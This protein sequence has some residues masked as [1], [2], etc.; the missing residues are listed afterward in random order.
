MLV[1]PEKELDLAGIKGVEEIDSG[2]K[3]DRS[4]VLRRF[5]PYYNGS[6]SPELAVKRTEEIRVLISTDILSEGLNLQDATRL[7]NFDLH[8]NPVRLMQRI[9][10][11]DRRMNP[12]V[13]ARLVADH[14]DQKELRGKTTYWNFLPP[15]ELENLLSLYAR[16]SSKTLRISKTFGIEGKKLLR[17][18]DDYDALRNLNEEYEGTKTPVEQMYLEYYQLLK[19]HPDLVA[20]LDA[21]PGRVFSGRDAPVGR[22]SPGTQAVFFCYRLPKP[23]QS[24]PAT[25]GNL[26]WTEAAGE[27]CWLLYDLSADGIID[28]P[29][30]IIESIRSAPDTPRHCMMEGKRLSELRRKVERRIIDTHL[31]SM[32][33]PGH[34]KAFL[35]CWM[36]LSG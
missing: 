9:G 21:L 5:A 18:E 34:V 8:W 35:K 7:I 30:Q 10:R 29:P 20:K 31:K 19:D 2:R 36:E 32:N 11:V 33:A 6:S 24:V 16:I 25:E 26:E 3:V 15:Q 4:A 17:P 13:E 28:D 1:A 22:L 12:D 23:D 27:T 14:P